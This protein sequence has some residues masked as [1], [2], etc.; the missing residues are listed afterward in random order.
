VSTGLAPLAH[1]LETAFA[2]GVD[3]PLPD[4]A[5]DEL[6]LRVF[7]H[8]YRTCETY[9]RFC[10]G[11][12]VRPETVA[13]WEDVPPVPARAFRHVEL[14]SGPR[15]VEAT[16]L[17][18]GTTAGSGARGRHAVPRMSLYRASLRPNFR[19]HL[20]PEGEPLSLVSLVPSP[21]TVPESSLSAMIGDVAAAFCDR[22]WWLT[23]PGTG[24]DVDA[25][26]EAARAVE[27]GGRAVLMAGTAFAFVHLL[28]GLAAAGRRLRLPEGTRVMETG[29]FKGRS[30]SVSREDLY[31]GIEERLGVPPGRVVNEYGMT[32]LL[33]QLYEPVLREGPASRGRHVP[34]P[35]LR[36]R[37][38]DPATLEPLPRGRPGLLAFF[39]LANAG[40]V[41]HVLTEDLG[42]VAHDG[43]RLQGR[44]PGA[45]PRGCSMAM[46]E[47]MA[48]V[49][50]EG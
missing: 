31:A 35:W 14:L 33:S 26:V 8:Q 29:G 40:S 20:L 36:V 7:V 24:T 44:A 49:D 43:V 18:S 48:V 4:G 3:A 25:F 30:R 10:E 2:R 19:A 15:P 13:R 11:R 21:E 5:F 32:E 45:E 37:A 12:G 34:P 27:E 17:T 23:D 42:S 9:R 41:S 6:A 38:L 46:E 47:L 28:D 16:F 1:T 50:R 22:T 39:D